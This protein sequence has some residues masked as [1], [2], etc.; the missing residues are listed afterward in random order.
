M[1]PLDAVSPADL[2]HKLRANDIRMP[3]RMQGWTTSHTETWVAS[4]VEAIERARRAGIIAPGSAGA[5]WTSVAL[6]ERLEETLDVDT[7]HVHA[8]D[9]PLGDYFGTGSES[10]ATFSQHARARCP[11]SEAESTAYDL[12]REARR[13]VAVRVA[14]ALAGVLRG[15]T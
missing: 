11:E 2:H 13:K 14:G 8:P 3:P 9:A 15:S 10:T 5:R 4:S 6:R 7:S 12:R 1:E